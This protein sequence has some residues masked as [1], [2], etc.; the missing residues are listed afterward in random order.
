M[1]SALR[2]PTGTENH[3]TITVHTTKGK[4]MIHIAAETQSDSKLVN[5]DLS[6]RISQLLME[7]TQRTI[8]VSSVAFVGYSTW[9]REENGDANLFDEQVFVAREGHVRFLDP[10]Y[11][12][13]TFSP[14]GLSWGYAGS[15]PSQLAIAMLMEV[16]DDWNRV[17]RLWPRFLDHFVVKVPRGANWTADGA[18]I[19]A[20]ALALEGHQERSS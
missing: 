13:E 3:L 20:A 12:L 6:D 10:R 11:E 1:T 9:R 2:R 8:L 15:G 14:D 16:L 5:E 7:A 17:K 19:L 18:D 4:S